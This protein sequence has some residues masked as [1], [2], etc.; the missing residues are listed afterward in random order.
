MI[1]NPWADIVEIRDGKLYWCIGVCRVNDGANHHYRQGVA[2]GKVGNKGYKCIRWKGKKIPVHQ[3]IWEIHNGSIPAGKT[4]DH[5]DRN[6]LNNCIENL[7]LATKSQQN[8]NT[9]KKSGPATSR[10]KGVN[11][12]KKP[13]RWRLI[14]KGIYRGLF[15][16]EEDAATVY[17]FL[18]YEEYGAYAAL[19]TVP[20]PWLEE[21]G[22]PDL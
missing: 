14:F 2:L 5:I 21:D 3:V 18:A 12:W 10:F 17:N 11:A 19:N 13:G 20:Q 8:A 7:R 9:G 22:K 15:S 6:R 1:I 4:I 16:S